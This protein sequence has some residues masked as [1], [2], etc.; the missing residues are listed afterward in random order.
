ML[1]IDDLLQKL[2]EIKG[3]KGN[4]EVCKIGHFREINEMSIDD[5]STDTA[6]DLNQAKGSYKRREIVNIDTP[7]IGPEPY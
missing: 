3:K 6:I 7:D 2:I 5:I 4:L 1:Y